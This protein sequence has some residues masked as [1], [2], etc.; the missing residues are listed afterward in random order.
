MSSFSESFSVISVT[1]FDTQLYLNMFLDRPARACLLHIC[2]LSVSVLTQ[3][4]YLVIHGMN[5]EKNQSGGR[6]SSE[7]WHA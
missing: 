2:F 6:T 7:A 3:A 1:I 5:I 4:K